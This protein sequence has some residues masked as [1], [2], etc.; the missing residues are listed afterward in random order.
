MVE[1]LRPRSIL[2]ADDERTIRKALSCILAC[3]G[4]L[5]TEYDPQAPD[6]G[7]LRSEYDVAILDINMPGKDG[8]ALRDEILKHSPATPIIFVTGNL[9]EDVLNRAFK[10][11]C[12]RFITK[13]FTADQI[14]DSVLDALRT[15]ADAPGHADDPLR[16]I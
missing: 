14:R 12:C 3:D 16:H 8:F 5:V 1:M 13:P 6:D 11:G 2:V 15:R 7:L 9:S 4:H 10:D